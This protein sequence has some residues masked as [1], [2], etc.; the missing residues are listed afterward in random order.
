MDGDPMTEHPPIP[1][2]V[3]FAIVA[4][5][6]PDGGHESPLWITDDHTTVEAAVHDEP[7]VWINDT[8]YSPSKAR[9]LAAALL[10]AANR[11]EEVQQ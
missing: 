6:A 10:A 1:L 8:A 11:V 9:K 5:P 2:D 3:V 7:A 4:L